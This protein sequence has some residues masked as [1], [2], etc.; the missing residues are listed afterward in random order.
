MVSFT[1]ILPPQPPGSTITDVA[2]PVGVAWAQMLT[3]W[4][5]AGRFWN[6]ATMERNSEL[7]LFKIEPAL[8]KVGKMES[9]TLT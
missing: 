9:S 6:T 7:L 1:I 2:E 3:V 5:P 8:L 4:L